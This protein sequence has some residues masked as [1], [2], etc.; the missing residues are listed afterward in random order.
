MQIFIDTADIHEIK[1]A[2]AMAVLDGVTT[3]PSLIAKTGKP[4]EACVREILEVV[5]GPVSVEV[6]VLEHKEMM[7]EARKYAAWGKTKN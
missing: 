6:L 7:L 1:E 5:P 3:N 4:F 2:K